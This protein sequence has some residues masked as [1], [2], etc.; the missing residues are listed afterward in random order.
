MYEDELPWV[1]MAANEKVCLDNTFRI[2]LIFL[3]DENFLSRLP[4]VLYIFLSQLHCCLRQPSPIA[5][6]HS[7]LLWTT[8]W[9][10]SES[11]WR[12]LLPNLSNSSKQISRA[13]A[14][15]KIV[16]EES[17]V[18]ILSTRW[19]DIWIL[20]G[21]E[22]GVCFS[23]LTASIYHPQEIQK[24]LRIGKEALYLT[25]TELKGPDFTFS[26][27]LVREEACIRQRV[28]VG[29]CALPPVRWKVFH[30]GVV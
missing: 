30:W 22:I 2:Q 5:S 21:C 16:L 13:L 1:I 20:N 27:E 8:K 15:K 19:V 25:E 17:M 18:K 24:L 7:L 12:R 14:K 26:R 6:T 28:R 11:F 4:Q 23:S 9:M 10:S 29:L 3:H